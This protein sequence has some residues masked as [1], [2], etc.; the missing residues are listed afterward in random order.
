[1]G[2]SVCTRAGVLAARRDATRR[3]GGAGPRLGRAGAMGILDGMRALDVYKKLP[4]DLS[5]STLAGAALT[6]AAAFAV[7]FLVGGET[8]SYLSSHATT[9]RE[10]VRYWQ[11]LPPRALYLR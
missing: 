10:R 2:R 8:R 11:A 3:A 4:R 5:E 7:A 1:M 6:T 9:V